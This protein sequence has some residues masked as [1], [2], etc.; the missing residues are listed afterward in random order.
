MATK[1]VVHDTTP[2]QMPGD[3]T[4]QRERTDQEALDELRR[5]FN[6]RARCFPRWVQDGRVSA[7]DAQDRLDR[8]AWAIEILRA[9]IDR[10]QQA[11]GTV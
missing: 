8:I 5:E 9:H 2:G 4:V 6:V 7:T 11:A 1:L 10:Q 3:M